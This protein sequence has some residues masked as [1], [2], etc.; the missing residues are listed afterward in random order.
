MSYR[1]AF[2][3][4][5][6]LHHIL[7]AGISHGPSDSIINQR[8]ERLS[9]MIG[10]MRTFR[11][12]YDGVEWVSRLLKQSLQQLD[13]MHFDQTSYKHQALPHMELDDSAIMYLRVAFTVEV[14]LSRSKFA[15]KDD[16]PRCLAGLFQNQPLSTHD[17]IRAVPHQETFSKFALH[18]SPASLQAEWDEFFVVNGKSIPNALSPSSQSTSQDASGGS[19]ESLCRTSPPRKSPTRSEILESLAHVTGI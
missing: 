9:T 4:L 6:L 14:S 10:A 3:A 7:D 1:I 11:N 5:P 18:T 15:H 19:F 2:L 12:K 13:I 17:G 8:R 16:I